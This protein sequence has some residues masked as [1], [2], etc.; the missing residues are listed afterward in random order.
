MTNKNMPKAEILLRLLQK[1]QG[2]YEAILEI[3]QQENRKFL[4][5]RP[6]NEITPL[7]K[8]KQILLTCINDIETAL[9][10]IKEWWN[11]HKHDDNDPKTSEIKK[12]LHTVETTVQELLSLDKV[13]QQMC[14]K[15]LTKL[16]E[17]QHQKTLV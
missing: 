16:K 8:K 3:T 13:N 15:I 17:Q 2:Y 4:N 12:Q 6:F 5:D 1:E 9:K 14:Q 11:N 10:P 7:L